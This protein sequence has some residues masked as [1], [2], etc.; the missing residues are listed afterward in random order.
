MD[1]WHGHQDGCNIE[2]CF[3]SWLLS[4]CPCDTLNPASDQHLISPYNNTSESFI[5]I[6]R[7]KEMI[8]NLR[9][10]DCSTNSPSQQQRTCLEN[11]MENIHTD[12]RVIVLRVD[13][14]IAELTEHSPIIIQNSSN[15]SGQ[16]NLDVQPY[17]R[18]YKV[19]LLACV[20]NCT[21][22]TIL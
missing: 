18:L 6:M 11:C 7:I 8:T 9:S 14:F 15:P 22:G 20:A 10:F 17:D 13:T 3:W 16:K 21:T 1:T 4:F 12:V 5:K 2:G 19:L